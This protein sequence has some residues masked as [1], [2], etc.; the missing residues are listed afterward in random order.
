MKNILVV[1]LLLTGAS[2]SAQTIYWDGGGDETSWDDPLNWDLDRVPNADDYARV[3]ASS[4]DF[5]IIVTNQDAIAGKLYLNAD[6]YSISFTINASAKLSVSDPDDA[7]TQT[8]FSARAINSGGVITFTN[9]GELMISEDGKASSDAGFSISTTSSSGAIYFKNTGYILISDLGGT[10]FS[11][12]AL[13]ANGSF[14]NE[15]TIELKNTGLSESEAF[16]FDGNVDAYNEGTMIVEDNGYEA[17]TFGR[18]INFTNNSLI[19][20]KGQITYEMLYFNKGIFTNNGLLQIDATSSDD[21]TAFSFRPSGNDRIFNE[22]CGVINITTQVYSEVRNNNFI[23]KGIFTSAYTGD[24]NTGTITN[25]G[26]VRTPD[27]SGNGWTVDGGVANNG[28]IPA[29]E[30]ID[31]SC[32]SLPGSEIEALP[33]FSSIWTRIALVVVIVSLV[34]FQLLPGKIGEN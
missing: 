5:T 2:I 3:N 11:F 32:P 8:A 15:G 21:D 18:G 25:T 29:T 26:E 27:G 9:N 19:E 1:L 34:L 22:L 10:G 24:G 31:E 23:N 4:S 13:N 28:P 12:T 20:I 6:D 7:F 17:F 33:A 16:S 30:S 14:L